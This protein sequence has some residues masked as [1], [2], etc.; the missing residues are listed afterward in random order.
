[1]IIS[2]G[3]KSD[4]LAFK[5][6]NNQNN[7]VASI[8]SEQSCRYV[9]RGTCN[10]ECI[11]ILHTKKH[12]IP[13]LMSFRILIE[14]LSWKVVLWQPA[15][16]VR[17]RFV[18]VVTASAVCNVGVRTGPWWSAGNCVSDTAAG[19]AGR[20]LRQ[21]LGHHQRCWCQICAAWSCWSYWNSLTT[22]P[23]NVDWFFK[24]KMMIALSSMFLNI[25][26][27]DFKFYFSKYS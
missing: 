5:S 24:G 23:P 27:E 14:F 25:Y 19:A 2:S 10:V 11:Y 13:L 16:C 15:S 12:D 26:T 17:K 20:Q 4:L 8:K 22:N 9:D 21:C 6:Y 7:A 1:M 18:L 3:T